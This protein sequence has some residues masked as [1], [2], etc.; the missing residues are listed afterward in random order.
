MPK[1]NRKGR[2]HREQWPVA[3][4]NLA[5][6]ALPWLRL[7]LVI[8]LGGLAN[9]SAA[10]ALTLR[11]WKIDGVP[12]EALVYL[13]SAAKTKAAPVVFAFHGHGGSMTNA[14][15]M[16]HVET[17][18]PEAMVVYMQGVN[19]PGRLTDPNG[20]APGWQF[21]V[22]DHGDRDL[23]FF[24]AVLASLKHDYKVDAKRI[25]ATGHSNGG[26]FTYLLWAARP[27]EFA[28]FAPS[29]SL[30]P[31]LVGLPFSTNAN[32]AAS[33]KFIPK[34]ILHVA[35]E[36]DPLVKFDWQ[37]Q[38][39]DAVRKLNQCGEGQPWDQQER[40]T[41]YLSKVNGDVVTC[42]HPGKHNFPAEAAGMIVK[43]FKERSQP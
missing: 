29:A 33:R 21:A 24:D 43:F 2:F 18:W 40:C 42:I 20:K 8:Y 26:S 3:Q 10:A 9:L 25:Y 35:G 11:E 23:K 1:N 13:P 15:R 34:P 22:G 27:N 37:K 39:I 31:S 14:A 4:S 19:T 17:I 16:F 28:A 6:S 5:A 7:F 38:M 30:L 41:I 12:R 36:N 32:S